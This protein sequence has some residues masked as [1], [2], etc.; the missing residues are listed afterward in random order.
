MQ[1][2]IGSCKEEDISITLACPLV[3]KHKDRNEIILF[4]G[5]VHL[6]KDFIL[7]KDGNKVFGYLVEFNKQG[8]GKIIEGAYLK[9]MSQEHGII[10]VTDESNGLMNKK[11]GDI[12]GVLPVHSCLTA[13]LM[14]RYLTLDNKVIHMMKK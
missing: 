2:N 1:L 6:S 12:L 5:A 10:K 3:A 9:G 4:G 13:D 11:I 14:G 7:D 8:W